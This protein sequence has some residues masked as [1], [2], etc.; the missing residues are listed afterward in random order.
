MYCKKFHGQLVHQIISFN[1]DNLDLLKDASYFLLL[2]F[3]SLPKPI[4]PKKKNNNKKKKN[5][6]KI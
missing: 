3:Y 6:K 1:F 2:S 5:K 4:F